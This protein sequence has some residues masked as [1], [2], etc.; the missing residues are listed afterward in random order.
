MKAN[1]LQSYE[2]FFNSHLYFC[3]FDTA[4]VTFFA[5]TDKK[6]AINVYLCTEVIITS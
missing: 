4:K 2:N 3:L 1:L 5:D 6:Y